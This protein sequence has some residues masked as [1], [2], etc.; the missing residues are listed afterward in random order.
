MG[1]KNQN[2]EKAD[3]EDITRMT[4]KIIISHPD[5][6]NELKGSAKERWKFRY[7]QKRWENRYGRKYHTII[8]KSGFWE[9]VMI[10]DG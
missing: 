8:D 7:H 9:G 5:V 10:K 4:G 1:N 3:L 2:V 6:V